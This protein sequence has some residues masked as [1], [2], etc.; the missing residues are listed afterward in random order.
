MKR[1]LFVDDEQNILDGL[2]HLLWKFR[3]QMDM[4]FA[5]GGEAA[6]EELRKAPFDVIVSDMRMPGM[7]G[8]ALL[9]KVK[10]EYPGIVRIVLSGHAEQ[11]AIFRALPVAHQFLSKPCDADKLCNV[12]ERACRLRELLT[13]ESLRKALGNIDRLPSLPTTYHEL[14]RAMSLQDASV[15]MIARIVRRDPAMCAKI[16][17]L[18]NSACFGP[19]RSIAS[20]DQAVVYLGMELIK[21]LAL[22]VHVFGDTKEVRAAGPSLEFLQEHA[23]LTAR[24]ASRLLPKQAQDIFA[25]ALLH[26]IGYIILARCAPDGFKAIVENGRDGRPTQEI[27]KE[28]LGVTHAEVGAY[29]LGLWGLPYPVVEGVAFHHNPSAAAAR[30]FDIPSALNLADSLVGEA[31]GNRAGMTLHAGAD[32][33]YLKTLDVVSQLPKWSEIAAEEVG[34]WRTGT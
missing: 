33:D 5:L 9:Q 32:M 29:L 30:G 25:A 14:M 2:R 24:V 18:V 8:A 34:A 26:D 20:I 6:L 3:R 28:V 21:N 19:S 7:D 15:Q 27:E 12:V 31:M 11:E 4:A 1:I 17:Q 16:L 22:M 13:D 10:E 23:L